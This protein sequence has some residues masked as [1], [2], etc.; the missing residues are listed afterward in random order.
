MARQSR[1]LTSLLVLAGA[2]STVGASKK[3]FS[4]HDDL[5]AFPQFQVLFPDEYIL[6]PQAR[7]LLEGH[8]SLSSFENSQEGIPRQKRSQ[9]YLGLNNH[10]LDQQ[11]ES[12]DSLDTGDHTLEEMIL[13]DQ[14]YLCQIPQVQ[15]DERVNG[16]GNDTAEAD[17]Q[18]E[19]ARATDRGLELL[20]EMEGKCMYYISG[21]W[22]YSFCYKEK[23]KQFHALPSGSG[24]PNYPPMEDPTT[25][26]FV[27]GRFPLGGGEGAE[28][29]DDFAHEGESTHKKAT[30]STT[31]VAE[32]QTKGGSRY[33]VQRLD[34]GTRC[35]LTGRRRKIEVQFHCHPQ[36]TDRIGW[37]K[38]T[39]TCSYLMII[40]TPRLCNDAVFLPPQQDEVHEI[41]CRQIL[42]PD[43]VSDWKA[44]REA[45]IAQEHAEDAGLT[46]EPYPIVGDIEVGA[47]RLVGSEGKK[48]EKGRVA[49]AGEEKVDV[50]AKRENGQVYQR[51]REELLKYDIDP[52]KLE[53][54]KKGVDEMAEGKDWKLELI[55]VNGE[56]HL[57][58]LLEEPEQAQVEDDQGPSVHVTSFGP[59]D[60]QYKLDK[61]GNEGAD[62]KAATAEGA[63]GEPSEESDEPEKRPPSESDAS[64]TGSEEV[65]KDE[66]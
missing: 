37:I 47:Q 27:L 2:S 21:W 14:R 38:E 34:D 40:Y 62:S 24:V 51:T 22:S 56:R 7:E 28:E 35:D 44:L 6:E 49:S 25:Q 12:P 41:E 59:S 29:E 43:Q 23:V 65:F 46:Q 4:V 16:T 18:K 42:T 54:L 11:D 13:G 53:D 58:V 32:L 64:E 60:D 1:I 5:L 15:L 10:D 3:S 39:A 63:A 55:T 66:L 36:S 30:A 52:D 26:S 45:L 33:L 20:R 48:I 17:E 50:V 8:S 61:P 19:L 31:D 9:V 57:N